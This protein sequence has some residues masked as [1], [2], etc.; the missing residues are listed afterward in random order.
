MCLSMEN[1]SEGGGEGSLPPDWDLFSPFSILAIVKGVEELY[2]SL[3]F[4]LL[5]SSG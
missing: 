1:M 2:V 4:V 3:C 5:S